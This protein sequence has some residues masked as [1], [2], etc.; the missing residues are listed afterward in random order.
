MTRVTIRY[1]LRL[2]GDMFRTVADVED[3]FGVLVEQGVL[4]HDK[5]TSGPRGG[6]YSHGYLVNPH[7]LP[8]APE[9][10]GD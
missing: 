5:G 1:I 9:V 8:S 2:G 3:G 10:G 4:R 7:V 6:R